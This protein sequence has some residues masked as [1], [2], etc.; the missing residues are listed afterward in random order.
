MKTLNQYHNICHTSIFISLVF[1]FFLLYWSSY[2]VQ[3][4]HPFL[5]A[6][7]MLTSSSYPDLLFLWRPIE[8]LPTLL[9]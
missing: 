3:L 7:L 4:E 1:F 9:I 5:P 6:V 8:V 2:T